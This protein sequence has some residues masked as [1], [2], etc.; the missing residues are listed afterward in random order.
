MCYSSNHP[1]LRLRPPLPENQQ[2]TYPLGPGRRQE[3]SKLRGEGQGK[4]KGGE[5]R[6]RSW[7]VD[8]EMR[9][10]QNE[11]D[12]VVRGRGRRLAGEQAKS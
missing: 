3:G 6:K 4:S 7:S 8:M 5:A 12:C 9:A 1:C 10:K 11:R 2:P